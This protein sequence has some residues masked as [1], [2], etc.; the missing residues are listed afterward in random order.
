MKFYYLIILSLFTS[1][2][3]I[4]Q[5]G[6]V[7]DPFTSLHQS[8][9]VT[10][11]GVYYF[12]IGGTTF[13][14]YVDANGYTQIAIDF[15]NGSGNLPQSTSLNNST[16]GILSA[17]ALSVLTETKEVRM[18][19]S[20][21]NFDVTTNNTTIISRVQSN[22]T[23]HQGSAD[24]TINDDWIGTN[25]AYITAN[26]S[27]A[28]GSGAS[29]HQNIVHGCGNTLITHWI[30]SSSLQMERHTDGD[31]AN[32]EYMQLWVKGNANCETTITSLQQAA[33]ITSAGIYCFDIGGVTFDTYVNANGYVQVAFD[34]GNGSGNLPQ[35][36]SLS[37]AA[38]GILSPAVLAVL[39][40]ASEAR[41]SSSTG[42]FDVTTTNSTILSRIQSNTTLHQ[43][44]ADNTI[45]DDWTGTNS[46]YI[47]ANASCTTSS[48][49]SLHQNIVHGCGNTAVTHWVPTSGVQREIYSGG[50]IGNSEYF[51]LWVKAYIGPGDVKT[52][53]NLWLKANEETNCT[54]NGCG[55]TSWGDQSPNNQDATGTGN[56][57]YLSS[58]SNFN[59]GLNFTDDAQPL[60]GAVSR[61]N[62][63]ASTIFVV[64]S[65]PSV[66]DKCL[67]EIGDGASRGFFIDRRYAGNTSYSLQTDEKSI[68]TVSDPGAMTDAIIYQDN[69]NI[70]TQTKAFST[71]W[72]TGTFYLG[73]DRSGGNRL[74]GEMAEVIFYDSQ[75]SAS[76]Q[77]KVESYLGIKYGIS[78]TG[79][80]NG[81]GATF[82]A[83][84]AD[85]INEGDYVA[86]DGTVIW[87]G[88]NL[89][90]HHND[91]TGIGRDDK[92]ALNQQKSISAN[93][94]A[95]VII[96]KGS[97]FDDDLDFILWGNDDASTNFTTVDKAPSFDVRTE[98]EWRVE[99]SGTP[100][101]VSVSAIITPNSGNISDYALLLDA[102]GIFATGA[103]TVNATSISGDTVIFTSVTLSDGIYFTFAAENKAPG[104]ITSDL[105]LWLKA[106][107]ATNCSTNG[108]AIT[109]WSDQSLSSHDASGGG[110]TT[111]LTSF[112][113]Y[114]PGLS[115]TDDA[116]PITG[117]INRTKGGAST[118]F[119]VGEVGAVADKC[120]IE[121]GDGASRGFFIDMRYAGN[122]SFSVQTNEKSIW[123][124]SDPGAMTAAL[125]FENASHIASP[126]KTFS[127]S[128]TNGDY[129]LGDDRTGGN[130]L[131]GEIAEVIFYDEQLSLS[132]QQK[133]ESYLGIK[134]GITLSKNTNGDGTDFEAPNAD[135]IHEG[136][137]VA[138]D[139]T[140]IWDASANADFHNDV[141]GIGRDEAEG[142]YQKQSKSSDDSTKIYVSTL[143][144]DNSSNDGTIS[145]E[146]SYIMIG[147]DGGKLT[148]K[149]DEKPG[150]V[151]SR[152]QREWKIV[153]TNFDDNFSL[154]L[155]WDSSGTFDINDI[156]LLF[157]TDGDFS[158]ANVLGTS[159]G[160]S[161]SVGSMII[162][163]ISTANIPKNS[164]GFLS[165]GSVSADTP[166]PVEL[167]SF[168]VN[169]EPDES[170]V[171]TWQTATEINNDYFV[172]Q[173]SNDQLLWRDLV[174]IDGVG[175]AN[176]T[177]AYQ[178]TDLSPFQ[179]QSYYRLKQ[180]DFDGT[181]S[182]SQT[183]AFFTSPKSQEELVLFPNPT[184]GIVNLSRTVDT[185]HLFDLKG[186]LLS[187]HKN[188]EKI[189]LSMFSKGLYFV[190]IGSKTFKINLQ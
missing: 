136:D 38:R 159:E 66:S 135:G 161:F 39:T 174:T 170:A 41:F 190:K 124:M 45:N 73:D 90:T 106:D 81:L 99:V 142:L 131:S 29:L 104:G 76:D 118:I 160:L 187:S 26:A 121:I 51:Q 139:G 65:V 157:D 50:E 132:N 101:A 105:N 128:W 102:D 111:Y 144:S 147:H 183:Q 152:L 20:T 36:T 126:T 25:S 189:D 2:A 33:K 97:A 138:S 182:Y 89:S 60:S 140:V 171:I 7:G 123:S 96:D 93:N 179:G 40:E 32:S 162:S 134:Y 86:S 98:R 43:G 54:A 181:T 58:F 57:T 173:R 27:C 164:S 112:S 5:S 141:I 92:S 165:I 12:D 186:V 145:N 167:L 115:F 70:D 34:Y 1:L 49:T 78:L 71:S 180:V 185:A 184:T 17:A 13:D 188:V 156:R 120:L 95:M 116:T 4:G 133:V 149:T 122:T 127:T 148:G 153:N 87:D 14:T 169:H 175:N 137:Y 61:T 100:G 113:N 75:L 117:T 15:G 91:I 146:T 37:N 109:S 52:N 42:T 3:V 31:I 178:S 16:R 64:G 30:P 24:N 6:T 55:I 151:V 119:I 11:A 82:E 47:T 44:V 177:N 158:D 83:P 125:L 168:E 172:L 155:E 74:S 103:T 10:S 67:I 79:D 9:S 56:T 94:D 154:K 18:S 28:S 48:G 88:S 23:L 46:A 22:T 110:N 62:G 85:G 68:W 107:D 163:N 84:N 150:A 176:N 166:L 8:A 19:S 53:L 21:G 143:A 72:T 35:S 77:Q 108:C 130:R 59:P 63:T 80:N 69:S 114:N 129:T